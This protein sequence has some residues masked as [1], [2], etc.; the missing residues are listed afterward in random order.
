M[1]SRCVETGQH[2][3][4]IGPPGRLHLGL[5]L[6]RLGLGGLRRVPCHFGL[7][8]FVG[9]A[10]GSIDEL[11]F[12]GKLKAMPPKLVSDDGRNVVI[13]PLAYCEES[14]LEA[15]AALRQFPIIP[16][17]LCGSQETL[18]RKAVKALLR[19]WEKRHPG[20]VETILTGIQNVKP[21][22]LLDRALFDFAAVRATGAPVAEG[23]RAFDPEP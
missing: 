17:T 23:D 10:G 15:Y 11:F 8:L 16:C 7:G 18:Q 14:D 12:G 2:G 20:R 6:V 13:R 3:I 19:E 5:H 9:F 21:S 4:Q 1:G 22:H